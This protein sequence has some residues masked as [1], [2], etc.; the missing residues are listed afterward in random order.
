MGI[1]IALPHDDRLMKADCLMERM[2]G[3]CAKLKFRQDGSLD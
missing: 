1:N 3:E 2:E